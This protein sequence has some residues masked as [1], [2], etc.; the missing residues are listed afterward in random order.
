[1]LEEVLRFAIDVAIFGALMEFYG[2][3]ERKRERERCIRAITEALQDGT[4]DAL[5]YEELG[6]TR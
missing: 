3:R 1:M 2:R 4:F 6:R 5:L